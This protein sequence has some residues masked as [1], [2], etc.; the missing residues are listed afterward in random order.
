MTS[1]EKKTIKTLNSQGMTLLEVVASIAI[2]ALI[3]LGVYNGTDLILQGYKM[4]QFVYK[5]NS[6]I[7]NSLEQGTVPGTFGSISFDAGGGTV[8]VTGN[9][10]KSTAT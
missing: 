4:G 8:V 3:S 5:S 7:A 1:K 2:L 10:H 6:S 9:F